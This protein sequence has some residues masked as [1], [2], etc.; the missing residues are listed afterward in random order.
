MQLTC[1]ACGETVAAE[2]P[3]PR[4]RCECGEP[5]WVDSEA[6]DI[7]GVDLE[8]VDLDDRM[9]AFDDLLP[10]RSPGGLAAAV[11]DTPLVRTSALDEYAGCRVRVKDESAHSTGSFKDRGSAV[12]VAAAVDAGAPAV[13]TVSHGNMAMSTAAFA[14][15]ADLPCVVLVPADIS[16]ERLANVARF[17]PQIVRVDG[18]YGR[19]YFEALE[20]GRERGIPFVNSDVPL[21]VAGQKTTALEILAQTAP[22]FPDAIVLPVSS[23]GHASG[24][25]KALRELSAAGYDDLPR[26]YLAQAAACD[27][28]ATAYRDGAEEVSAITGEET[29]A[30]SIANADPPSGSRALRAA[31]ATGGAV[32]SVDDDAIREARDLL[33]V[34]AGLNVE[35]ASA[36]TLAAARQLADRGALAPDDDVVLVATGSGFKERDEVAVEAPTVS[37]SDVDDVL[38]SVDAS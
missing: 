6:F 18:D 1:E 7:G 4:A 15:A 32:C 30:Y 27:P 13:G 22:D 31:R 25:W 12:G 24:A 21:R 10:I 28:I 38:S 34:D 3:A 14:A 37:L 35:P 11:G 17:D 23:G 20:A 36:T 29:I 16:T 19:L 33:A 8:G 5:L 2:G 26:L 9:W